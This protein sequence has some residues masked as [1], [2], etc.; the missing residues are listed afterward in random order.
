MNKLAGRGI[1][2]SRCPFPL[3][4]TK[5]C[6]LPLPRKDLRSHHK[7]QA[8]VQHIHVLCAQGVLPAS[9]LPLSPPSGAEQD[10]VEVDDVVGQDS[11]PQCEGGEDVEKDSLSL[12]NLQQQV[13][14]F[15][16]AYDVDGCCSMLWWYLAP[17]YTMHTCVCQQH[18][19][20]PDRLQPCSPATPH[21]WQH[22]PS[23]SSRV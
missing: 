18:V 13:C 3:T 17:M 16:C 2:E 5:A 4:S 7:I 14:L 15:V 12:D 22:S 23:S 9:A 6:N 10:D 21:N 8:L 19:S 11:V 20:H 1:I